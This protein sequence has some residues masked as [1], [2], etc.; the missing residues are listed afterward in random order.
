MET[1]FA[2][3]RD[4]G[5]RLAERLSAYRGVKNVIVLALPRGGVPVAFEI[6]KALDAPLDLMLVRKLGVP[7]DEELA[8][9]AVALGGACVFNRSV[10]K[11]IGIPRPLIEDV[12]AAERKELSR[13]NEAYRGNRLPPDLK[14]R[15]VI[16]VDDGMA[17]GADMRAAVKAVKKQAPARVIVAVPVGSGEACES[18]QKLADEVV[19]LQIPPLFFGVGG[20]YEDFSQTSDEEVKALI[21]ESQELSH[22][23][24]PSAHNTLT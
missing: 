10:I 11:N 1:F 23:H 22:H 16:L 6:A 20:A 5:K 8:M 2:D 3:R 24:L 14:D 12:I 21:E 4:A 18:L 9:G 7:D 13:R 19:C 17:T 15:T